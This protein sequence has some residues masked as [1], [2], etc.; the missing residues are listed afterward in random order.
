M[1]EKKMEAEIGFRV[2]GF[3]VGGHGDLG[4]RV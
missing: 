1:M 3:L 4:F 2:Q